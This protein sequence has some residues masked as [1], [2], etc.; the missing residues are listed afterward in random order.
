MN[1]KKVLMRDAQDM[2]IQ[3]SPLTGTGPLNAWLVAGPSLT[4][5]NG[6]T[7]PPKTP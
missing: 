7:R 5:K 6:Q 1:V 3:K 2:V 4:E